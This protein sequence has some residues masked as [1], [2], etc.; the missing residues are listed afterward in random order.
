MFGPTK[1]TNW[2][3]IEKHLIDDCTS[4]A[5]RQANIAVALGLYNFAIETRLF[6]RKQEFSPLLM[7][8]GR[9]V[10]YW[11]PIILSLDD[12]PFVPFID[13]RRSR[14]LTQEGRRFA[15][16]MMHER[17]RVADPDYAAVRFAIFRF[18]DKEN[19]QRSPILYTD[20]GIELFSFDQMEDM[21]R[22]T[23]E[24]WHEICTERE[25]E[26]RRSASGRRGSLI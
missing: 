26:A 6:G 8:S 10:A 16:S 12:Q 9:R 1:T 3:K 25:E 20:E 19:E 14:G 23:Y 2:T 5:E 15:F 22:T 4:D 13:P 18:G 17:I 7:G 24:L 11:I 21:I